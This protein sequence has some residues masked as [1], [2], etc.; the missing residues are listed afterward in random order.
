[1]LLK[2]EE[3]GTIYYVPMDNISA[4]GVDYIDGK[5]V[6]TIGAVKPLSSDMW[7]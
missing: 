3:N 4:F 2:F 5:Y 1:M 7:M 6:I